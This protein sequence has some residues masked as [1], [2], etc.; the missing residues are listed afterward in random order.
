MMNF[1]DNATYKVARDILAKTFF[2]VYWDKLDGSQKN[3]V[4]H[5]LRQLNSMLCDKTFCP[6]NSELVQEEAT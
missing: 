5:A 1:R 2:G 6:V 4:N 3:K